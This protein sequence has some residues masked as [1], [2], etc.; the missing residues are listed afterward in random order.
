[1][2]QNEVDG[3]PYRDSTQGQAPIVLDTG[4][5]AGNQRFFPGVDSYAV[6]LSSPA[7]TQTAPSSA[8]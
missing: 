6:G 2:K 5:S 7:S 1:V 4:S 3:R 8:R